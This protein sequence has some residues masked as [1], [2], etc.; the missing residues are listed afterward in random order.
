MHRVRAGGALATKRI[1]EALELSFQEAEYQ[2]R[3]FATAAQSRDIVRAH[4]SSYDRALLEFRQVIENYERSLGVT[5]ARVT[6]TGGGALFH[7][8]KRQVKDVL[9]KEV[10][11]AQP[12]TK[13]AYPAFMEDLLVQIGPAFTV[14]LGAALRAYD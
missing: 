4:E 11:I 8:L 9:R 13:A 2:K 3:N 6:L 10:A 7:D 1:A 12:F 14:A 5:V